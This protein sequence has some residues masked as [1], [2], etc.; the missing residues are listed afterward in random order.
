MRGV[1][2]GEVEI[3]ETEEP[4]NGSAPPLSFLSRGCA[5]AA[6]TGSSAAAA[7]AAA[8][9]GEHEAEPAPPVAGPGPAAAAAA[10]VAAAAAAGVAGAGA[11]AGAGAAGAAAMCEGCTDEEVLLDLHL[12]PGRSKRRKSFFLNSTLWDIKQIVE[13]DLRIPALVVAIVPLSPPHQNDAHSP[14]SGG[15]LVGGPQSGGPQ[16]EGPYLGGPLVGGPHSE[17][18]LGGPLGGPPRSSQGGPPGGPQGGPP[19]VP[20]GGPPGGPSG[21]FLGGPPCRLPW[22]S[23]LNSLGFGCSGGKA[24]ALAVYL[25]RPANADAETALP[26]LESLGY[27]EFLA[28]ATA[29]T[30]LNPKP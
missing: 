1:N 30:T 29:G 9:A 7:A 18:L 10:G 4:I 6:G 14:Q 13:K 22:S 26:T 15:P 23:S 11:G 2:S 19:S 27:P 17:G 12:L 28:D 16:S 25:H 8:V 20:P 3:K 5:A 24:E 21:G